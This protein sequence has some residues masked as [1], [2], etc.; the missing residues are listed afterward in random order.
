MVYTGKPSRG[1]HLCRKRRVKC[2]ES[3]PRCGQCIKLGKECPGYRSESDLIFRNE[4]VAVIQRSQRGD[5]AKAPVPMSSTS[6][7]PS[8][9]SSSELVIINTKSTDPAPDSTQIARWVNNILNDRDDDPFPD[10]NPST[11]Q[12]G[13]SRQLQLSPEVCARAF[14]FRNFARTRQDADF[15]AR[16]YLD[17]LSRL[18][19]G[20][21]PDSALHQAV[22]AVSLAALGGYPSKRLLRD[23]ARH[24]YGKALRAARNEL[25]DPIRAQSDESIMTALIFT[26]YEVVT[27]TDSRSSIGTNNWA[28]HVDGAVALVKLRGEKIF[29]SVV[30][31]SLFRAVR[32]GMLTSSIQQD[33]PVADFPGPK[34]WYGDESA[35]QNYSGT[36]TRLSLSLPDYRIRAKEVLKEPA[37]PERDSRILDVVAAA[38]KSDAYLGDWYRFTPPDWRASTIALSDGQNMAGAWMGPIHAYEDVFRAYAVN[39]YRIR[40]LLYHDLILKCLMALETKNEAVEKIERS[41]KYVS[42]TMVDEICASVPFHLQF[43]LQSKAQKLGQD[44]GATLAIGAYLLVSP[45]HTASGIPCIPERQRLWLQDKLDLIAAVFGVTGEQMLDMARKQIVSTGPSDS[46]LL[47]RRDDM[48]GYSIVEYIV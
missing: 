15:S 16:G 2:D 45:L 33:R 25:Q 29:D 32:N 14:F 24:Y 11:L 20:V 9:L 30:A 28:N 31:T 41:S 43:D 21:A 8:S 35:P 39:D 22:T 46:Q 34:G 44:E 10:L 18:F 13:L 5:A 40:R 19:N 26:L 3:K 47:Y 42:Q 27:T 37:S 23:Y 38:C 4:N 12:L 36:L 1:C 48:V 7:P 6:S 17:H